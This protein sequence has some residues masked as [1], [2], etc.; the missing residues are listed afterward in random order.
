MSIARYLPIL[1]LS[2]A[3]S[4]CLVTSGT[5]S[6]VAVDD[7]G[8]DLTKGITHFAYGSGIYSSRSALC[9]LFKGATIIIKNVDTG[10][11]LKGESPRRCR[12]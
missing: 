8:A 7:S 11:E 5:Y 6:I 3:L 9:S 2:S 4:G 1:A 10:E 12:S